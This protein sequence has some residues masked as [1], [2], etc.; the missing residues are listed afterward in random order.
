MHA[1]PSWN[2]HA[3]M[4]RHDSPGYHTI[5]MLPRHALLAKIC[6]Q[7][8]MLPVANILRHFKLV[9]GSK[10]IIGKNIANWTR[11]KILTMSTLIEGGSCIQWA[12]RYSHYHDWYIWI[13][14]MIRVKSFWDFC[15]RVS[16]LT[17]LG[18][19]HTITL[20]MTCAFPSFFKYIP[21]GERRSHRR[22]QI[23]NIIVLV[24]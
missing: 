19:K 16:E 12:I 6:R 20:R 11:I 8:H 15:R 18:V 4:K 1:I 22:T 2:W 7:H 23:V 9:W 21:C 14:I 24:I 3:N 17:L 13:W 5:L 10:N